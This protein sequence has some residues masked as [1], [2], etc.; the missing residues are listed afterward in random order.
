MKINRDNIYSK[1]TKQLS[2]LWREKV[3]QK[4]QSDIT[5]KTIMSQDFVEN[6]YSKNIRVTIQIK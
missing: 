4:Y 1:N 6:K 5:N 3:Q 2:R